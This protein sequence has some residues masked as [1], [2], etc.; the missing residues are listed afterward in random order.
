MPLRS[1]RDATAIG[2]AV[3]FAMLAVLV[4][5]GATDGFDFAVTSWATDPERNGAVGVARA[6]TDLGS[7]WAV[8]LIAAVLFVVLA[9]R[10]APWLGIVSAATI[11]VVALGN[12]TIKLVLG[13]ARPE[14]VGATLVEPGFSF[15][16]GHALMSATAYGV[17]AVLVL[18]SRLPRP[19]RAAIVVGLIGISFVVG[20]T[21]VYLGVHFVTDV[22][23]GWIAGAVIVLLY[24]RGTQSLTPAGDAPATGGAV[25]SAGSRGVDARIDQPPAEPGSAAAP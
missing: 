8:T 13:R 15:P 1:A 7:T 5:L 3:A 22:V 9:V 23:G 10:R 19:A 18:R 11:A 17:L 24:A 14:V 2:G 25:G 6:L 21:R 20:A 4:A 16:S 12:S